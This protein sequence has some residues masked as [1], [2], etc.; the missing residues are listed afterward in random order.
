MSL[1]YP[2][3]PGVSH[4]PPLSDRFAF[5]QADL[6]C[7]QKVRVVHELSLVDE[8]LG[9]TGETE[10]LDRGKKRGCLLKGQ[11]QVLDGGGGDDGEGDV[12]AVD[13]ADTHVDALG[14]HCVHRVLSAKYNY[15]TKVNVRAEKRRTN[16]I[17][18]II[19]TIT[20]TT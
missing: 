11:F 5:A 1:L 20:T 12:G 10:L 3:A 15:Y 7:F 19:I 16:I 13:L 9:S 17:S 2:S 18:G 6:V 14:L 8:T 4:D